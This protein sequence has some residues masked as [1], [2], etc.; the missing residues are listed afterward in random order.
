VLTSSSRYSRRVSLV[1]CTPTLAKRFASVFGFSSAARIPFPR[2]ASM[3][4]VSASPVGAAASRRDTP[5]G[6]SPTALALV[7]VSV[8]IRSTARVVINSDSL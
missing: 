2:A 7:R 4:A 8:M 3:L 1:H 6:S 5:P